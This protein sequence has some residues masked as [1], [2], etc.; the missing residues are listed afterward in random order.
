M[1]A[2]VV[3]VVVVVVVVAAVVGVAV[4]VAGG[5]GGWWVVGG[6]GWEVEVGVA[7]AGGV[8]AWCDGVGA[9]AGG[10]V[11]VVPLLVLEVAVERGDVSGSDGRVVVVA[12]PVWRVCDSNC[13]LLPE[14]PSS[15][16]MKSVPVPLEALT[17]PS[18]CMKPR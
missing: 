6:W 9:G 16:P 15:K 14:R 8:G 18:S 11:M 10:G 4:A 7:V 17:C 3:L 1:V 5:G 12:R 13:K 2:V